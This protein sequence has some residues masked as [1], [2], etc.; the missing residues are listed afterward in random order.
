MSVD[1]TRRA[2]CSGMATALQA[3]EAEHR[4]RVKEIL[5]DARF[6]MML[7]RTGT[8]ELHARPMSIARVSQEGTVYFSTSSDSVKVEEIE[9]DPRVDLVFQSRTQYCHAT[10]TAVCSHD[11]ALIDELWQADWKVWY[12]GKDDPKI[13]ILAVT[14][15]SAEYW[16]QSGSR[17]LSFLYRA[18]KAMVTGKEMETRP[19]DH[20]KVSL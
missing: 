3:T 15:T 1:G 14:L 20:G 17:G 9:A 19:E 5:E 6:V 16:D 2:S 4:A 12:S 10:G 13:L 18:A 7:T 11:R 8:G